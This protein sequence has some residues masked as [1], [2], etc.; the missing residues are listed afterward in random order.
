LSSF[1][2]T[3]CVGTFSAYCTGVKYPKERDVLQDTDIIQRGAYKRT[4]FPRY[5]I[6]QNFILC[7]LRR[8][9][10]KLVNNAGT[11]H[12]IPINSYITA[13]E[14]KKGGRN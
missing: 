12:Y 11:S 4:L 6:M 9:L 14:N 3:F 8:A 10:K 2:V 7:N 1:S 5:Y 13:I